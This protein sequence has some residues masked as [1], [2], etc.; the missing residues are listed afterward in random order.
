M[1]PYDAVAAHASAQ[2]GA[3][4]VELPSGQVQLYFRDPAGNLVELNWHD[5]GTL[6]R[7]RYP[8]L[9]RLADQIPQTPESERAALYLRD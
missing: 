9:R 4:L 5:A 3:E 7:S 6:D 2:W 8:T 1:R